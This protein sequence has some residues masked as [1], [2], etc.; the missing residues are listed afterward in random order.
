M[1][2]FDFATAQQILFGE[3]RSRELAK[4]AK[5]LGKKALLVTGKR[6]ESQEI[7]KECLTGTGLASYDLT[8]HAEP[9]IEVIRAA[10]AD[11][12]ME[13][14][15]LVIAMGGG[16]VLD[17]GKVMAAMLANGGDVLDYLEVVGLGRPLSKPSLPYIAIPTTAGTGSEVT[18]NAVLSASEHRVKVSMRSPY[19]L[20]SLAIIDPELSYSLSP[21][22]TASTG[23]DALTQCLEPFVSVAHNP[24]T[25]AIAF[26]GL[27]RAAHALEKAYHEPQHQKA[28]HDMALASL[29]GGLALANAKLGAVHGFAGVLGAMLDAPHGDIC[30]RLL[31][32]VTEAN[33]SVLKDEATLERYR[34]IAECLT[35][36]AS[37]TLT[38]LVDWLHTLNERLGIRGLASFGLE[39][40]MLDEIVTK[41]MQASSMKGNPVALT[42]NQL[43]AI[44]IAAL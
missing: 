21:A 26:E 28:R 27:A 16:S 37:A 2:A 1:K 25:D 4:H 23:L 30:A 32:I 39:A 18:R 24:L 38:D 41:S 22:L 3:G 19:M 12:E 7:L 5:A 29:C 10:L 13:G 14:C 17:S 44:L 40:T 31:P 35:A 8:I 42:E 11:G 33:I 36:K 34:L 20:P 15:D 6:P 43:R 9:S